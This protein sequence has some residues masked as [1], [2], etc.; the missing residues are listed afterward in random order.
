M[1]MGLQF[2]AVLRSSELAVVACLRQGSALVDLRRIAPAADAAVCRILIE[3]L[4]GE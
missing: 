3:S 4:R 1:Q 2:A